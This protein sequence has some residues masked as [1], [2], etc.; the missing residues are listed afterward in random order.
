MA[1]NGCYEREVITLRRLE[2]VQTEE[3]TG[4]DGDKGLNLWVQTS[5]GL[6]PLSVRAEDFDIIVW[7]S[8]IRKA[9]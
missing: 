3:F 6:V 4:A 2:V 1:R 9:S 5:R 7:K 8:K